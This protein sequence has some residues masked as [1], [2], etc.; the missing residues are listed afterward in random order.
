MTIHFTTAVPLKGTVPLGGIF[1]CLKTN[2]R[3]VGV[4]RRKKI[5]FRAEN[6]AQ[7]KTGLAIFTDIDVVQSSLSKII[8]PIIL[9]TEFGMLISSVAI[10]FSYSMLDSKHRQNELTLQAYLLSFYCEFLKFFKK[11]SQRITAKDHTTK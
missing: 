9:R 6:S 3:R 7:W 8:I 10:S 1:F 11:K 4:K 2:W 5:S